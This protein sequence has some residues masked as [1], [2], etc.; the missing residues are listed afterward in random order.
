MTNKKDSSKVDE[1][2]KLDNQLCFALYSANRAITRLYTPLLKPFGLTYPQYLVM[3]VLFEHQSLYIK[4]LG[5]RLQLDT[6]TLTPLLKRMESAGLLLRERQMDDE[7]KVSIC[8]T[9]KGLALKNSLS[10]VPLALYQSLS[11]DVNSISTLRN[12]LKKLVKDFDINDID[13]TS[14]E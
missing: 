9:E 14:G 1:Y 13:T 5:E 2:L 8:L 4:D 6:G 12:Q 3:L 10:E 7:R 11:C